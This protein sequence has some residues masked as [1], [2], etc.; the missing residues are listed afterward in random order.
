LCGG[1]L[2]SWSYR[3]IWSWTQRYRSSELHHL[4]LKEK[5]I[6]LE[7]FGLNRKFASILELNPLFRRR[8]WWFW[9]VSSKSVSNLV[10]LSLNPLWSSFLP[11]YSSFVFLI[12]FVL[13]HCL[14]SKE[15]DVD[16]VRRDAK[17]EIG[18]LGHISLCFYFF[19]LPLLLLLSISSF[20]NCIQPITNYM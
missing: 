18:I 14:S 16:D 17:E 3:S 19:N 8:E 13:F 7:Y 20:F 1:R 11:S 15:S 5:P 4:G 6:I 9:F 10:F 12:Q 2:A